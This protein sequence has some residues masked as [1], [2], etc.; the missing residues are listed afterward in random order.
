MSIV[1]L[2][3]PFSA[4]LLTVVT[5]CIFPLIP[6]YLSI[7][8]RSGATKRQA[9][10]STFLFTMG[11]SFVFILLGMGATSIGI[12]LNDNR[13]LLVFSGGLLLVFFGLLQLK[14]ISIPALE[15]NYSIDG[16]VDFSSGLLRAFVLGVI[17]ALGWTPC[18]GPVIGAVLTYTASK[19]G[20]IQTGA[21]YLAAFSIGVSIPF[22]VL[23]L[24]FDT[25]KD[26]ISRFNRFLPLLQK[27]TGVLLLGIGIFMIRSSWPLAA[28]IDNFVPPKMVNTAG[29]EISPTL[30]MPTEKPRLVMFKSPHCPVCRSMQPVLRELADDCR[31]KA[32]DIVSVDVTQGNNRE[33]QKR[34]RVQAF[35]TF[36]FLSKEGKEE[37]RLVG[38]I[39]IKD[40]RRAAS[41]LIGTECG[42]EKAEKKD[43]LN[44]IFSE[45]C[46]DEVL[47]CS[48]NHAEDNADKVDELSDLIEGD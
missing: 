1:E 31:G 13:A 44:Y 21:A 4:G 34:F 11:F 43:F 3:K 41:V 19:A 45:S 35:P 32:I 25:L 15:R 33:A 18:A 22:L 38:R 47:S 36:A 23:A 5:P 2:I 37:L 8:T 20:D 24:F 28:T 39:P 46:G 10:S 6:I 9:F 12:L 27:L 29:E 7:L 17:F 40:L 14:F 26:R 48:G 16:K 30:G 42:S